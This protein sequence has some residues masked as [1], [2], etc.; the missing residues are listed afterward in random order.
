MVSNG[1]R[2]KKR[3]FTYLGISKIYF[4]YYPRTKHPCRFT[5]VVFQDKDFKYTHVMF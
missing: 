2:Q 4:V 1:Y 5:F 3:L